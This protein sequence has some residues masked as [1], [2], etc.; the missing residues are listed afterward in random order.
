MKA[1]GRIVIGPSGG[2]AYCFKNS[3]SQN[4]GY[5]EGIVGELF[6]PLGHDV[7]TFKSFGWPG[8]PDGRQ[9]KDDSKVNMCS[10]I[11]D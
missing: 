7:E 3:K 11:G 8:K 10:D 1:T 5:S 9:I 2:Y 4:L 6:F